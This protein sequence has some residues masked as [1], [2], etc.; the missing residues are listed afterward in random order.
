MTERLSFP[1][2]LTD[3]GRE[4]PLASAED[5]GPY[6]E[7]VLTPELLDSIHENQYTRER[8][9]LFAAGGMVGG[10]NGAIWFGLLEDGTVQVVTVQNDDGTTAI[11]SAT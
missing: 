7:L 11:R 9:D 6:Y 3:G 8:A 10:A 1:V 5:F 4:V 2:V